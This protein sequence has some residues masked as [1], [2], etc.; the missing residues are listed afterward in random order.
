MTQAG[1]PHGW[2]A[3]AFIRVGGHCLWA[4]DFGLPFW[5]VPFSLA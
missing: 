2:K 4:C 1:I 3:V 5:V